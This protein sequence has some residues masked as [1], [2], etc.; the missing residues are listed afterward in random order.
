MIKMSEKHHIVPVWF[1][2]GVLLL[3]YGC[4]IF[5]SGLTEW[6]NPPSTV[7]AELHAPVWWGGLLIILGGVYLAVFRPRKDA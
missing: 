6:S 1:F 2:V 3:I 5:V 7:L 4:L